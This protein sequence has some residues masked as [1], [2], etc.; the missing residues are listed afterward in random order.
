M[1]KADIEA[2]LGLLRK[3]LPREI[4]VVET[5]NSGGTMMAILAHQK[6]GQK[7]MATRVPRGVDDVDPKLP[8][9]AQAFFME[10][11][12]KAQIEAQ[13]RRLMEQF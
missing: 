7:R 12:I 3:L 4:E 10:A 9:E 6:A 2:G 13:N 5:E 8:D 1:N 11:V